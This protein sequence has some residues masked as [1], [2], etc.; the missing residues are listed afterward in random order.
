[1][2]FLEGLTTDHRPRDNLVSQSGERISTRVFDAR[3][4]NLDAVGLAEHISHVPVPAGAGA[5]SLLTMNVDH[6]VHLR[7]DAEFRQAYA[8]AWAVTIDGAP[9]AALARLKGINF[10]ARVTG[11]DLMQEIVRRLTPKQHRPFLVVSDVETGAGAMAV[12][13][14]QGFSSRTVK[15][16]SPPFGFQADPKVSADLVAAIRKH[17][18]THLFMCVGAPKS[19]I[20]VHRQRDAL[21]D[22]YALCFGSA[23]NVMARTRPAAPAFVRAVGMEWAFRLLAEPKRLW[24]RYLVS[25]WAFFPAALAD[26]R[27][28]RWTQSQSTP[29]RNA[30]GQPATSRSHMR[31]F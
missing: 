18:T 30:A 13:A 10:Q 9:V 20:W 11:V 22:L 8:G 28:K 17:K 5:R 15:I 3:I 2:I 23:V 29:R 27:G 25:S 1:M 7:G 21:G 12:F 19:E 26:L 31:P 6:V 16:V 24:R 14:A 4:S